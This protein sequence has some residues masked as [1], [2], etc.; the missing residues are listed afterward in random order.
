MK[1]LTLC[2]EHF[3]CEQVYDEVETC[4]QALSDR[5]GEQRFFFGTQ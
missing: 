3:R 1:L 5:L 2:I 4:C